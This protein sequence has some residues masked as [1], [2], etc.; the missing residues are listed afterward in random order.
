MHNISHLLSVVALTT[1]IT[2]A[3]TIVVPA[4]GANVE[5][6]ST[7]NVWRAGTCRTQAFY[8]TTN[9]TSQITAQPIVIS[10]VD[11]RL[12]NTDLT[13]IVTYPSVQ[14][15]LQYSAV[16]YLTP[17]TTFAANRSVAFPTTP[18]FAGPVTTLAVAGTAPNDYFIQIPLTTP[19][20]YDP[21]TGQ[22]LL[23]EIVI[24]TAPSPLLGNSC[25]SGSVVAT[26]LSN[27]IRAVGSTTVLTGTQSA[28][29]P[30]A[31]FTYTAV[32]GSGFN[33]TLGQ[34]CGR[35][36]RSF[37]EVF[38]AS[39][40]DLS[41]Q[42]VTMLQNANGGYDVATT[43]GSALTPPTT[44]GLAL[45][46]DVVSPAIVL[47]FT[48]DYPGGST[49][50]IY[51]DSNGSILLG[52]TGT[53]TNT[54]TA[55]A[56]L[57]GTVPRI[58]PAMTD[59][60]PDDATNV[61]NVFAEVDPNNPGA[62]LITWWGV[63]CFGA[64]TP[65][66]FQLALVD[67]GTADI[68]QMRYLSLVND[69]TSNAGRCLTGFSLGNGASDVGPSDLTAASISTVFDAPPL[70]LTALTRP[71]INTPWDL[72]LGNIPATGLIGVDVYGIADPGLDDLFFV[73]LPGCGLR[74][75]LDIQNPW[76][77]TGST[78]AHGLS[79]PNEP[80]WT[81]LVFYTTSA[82]FTDPPLNSFGA[83]TAN[84]IAGTLGTL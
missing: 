60:L 33:T 25:S 24:L 2:V 3:Q 14:I 58:C 76:L 61:D 55:A 26:H 56:L 9:F 72:S 16:D 10:A 62:F 51:V 39:S 31:R 6:G 7:V 54:A 41:G 12:K 15:Y 74:S 78:H 34:G 4:A 28:F 69:S 22:D 17:S 82:V 79:L 71:V 42:T 75:T 19:F 37:Y 59:L 30:L 32:P 68:V 43:A 63:P 40:N 52:A 65:S 23:M 66:T 64:A 83:I 46:D 67:N 81:G 77:V 5:V 80:S 35:Q 44:T 50:T 47:P 73:G 53:S 1:S 8:D 84:G 57:N 70:S 29:P 27:S 36:A 13:N 48:F 38:P 21:S 11:F 49:N 20:V 18:N 45:G